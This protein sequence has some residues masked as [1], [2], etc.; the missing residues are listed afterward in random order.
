MMSPLERKNVFQFLS[1]QSIAVLATVDASG[2]PVANVVSYYIDRGWNLFFAANIDSRKVKNIANNKH[3]ALVVYSAHAPNRSIQIEGTVVSVRSKKIFKPLTKY[4]HTIAE[5][6]YQ[7]PLVVMRDTPSI[8][9]KVIPSI[10][11]IIDVGTFGEPV[12]F[13]TIHFHHLEG[14]LRDS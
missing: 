7:S 13:Q 8:L 12:Q 3:V 14:T 4:L 5:M 10:V 1:E 11:K 6:Q 2:F 9:Y